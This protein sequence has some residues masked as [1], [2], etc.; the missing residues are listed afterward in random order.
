MKYSVIISFA[1]FNFEIKFHESLELWKFYWKIIVIILNY[2]EIFNRFIKKQSLVIKILQY[3]IKWKLSRYS[4]T[5]ETKKTLNYRKL[6]VNKYIFIFFLF[7][8]FVY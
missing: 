8:K 5:S 2:L 4:P 6:W 7:M 3:K 1:E